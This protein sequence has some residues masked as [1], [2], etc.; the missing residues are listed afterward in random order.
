MANDP[1]R[2][3]TQSTRLKRQAR[4]FDPA[5]THHSRPGQRLLAWLRRLD[6]P[7]AWGIPGARSFPIAADCALESL[8]G[9]LLS[10]G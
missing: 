7:R 2:T 1:G 3:W 4:R 8:N 6:S 5:P 10:L 9:S